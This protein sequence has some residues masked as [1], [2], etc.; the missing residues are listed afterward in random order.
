MTASEKWDAGLPVNLRELSEIQG[1]SYKTALRWAADE[2]FPRV[3]RLLMKQDFF[4][5]WKAKASHPSKASHHQPTAGC[6]SHEQSLTS[7]SPA[8]LPPKAA[9]LL[10]AISSHS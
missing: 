1:V 5:W 2:S 3:G 8:A 6:K 9:R 7:G 4:R 10:D